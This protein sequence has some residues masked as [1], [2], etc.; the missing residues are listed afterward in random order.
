MN[1]II[2]QAL[3]GYESASARDF[4]EAISVLPSNAKKSDINKIAKR[5]SVD[6]GI[7]KHIQDYYQTEDLSAPLP[8]PSEKL[9]SVTKLAKVIHKASS[10][11]IEL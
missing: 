1:N 4:L 11:Q 3:E 5:F 10:V 2:K 8:V 9:E 7:V 6:S